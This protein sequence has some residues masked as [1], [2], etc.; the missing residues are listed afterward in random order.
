M[1]FHEKYDCQQRFFKSL[2]YFQF[3]DG[4]EK[5]FCISTLHV[6]PLHSQDVK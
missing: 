5:V 2:E 1:Y 4:E 6:T 3:M